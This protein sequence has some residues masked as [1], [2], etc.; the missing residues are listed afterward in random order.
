MPGYKLG[1]H[2]FNGQ[3]YYCTS[4]PR[5]ISPALRDSQV[6]FGARWP[7]IYELTRRLLIT[8]ESG[9]DQLWT[10]LAHLKL[11]CDSLPLWRQDTRNVRPAQACIIV[12]PINCGKTVLFERKAPS[13]G[14]RAECFFGD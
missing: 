11:S 8:P 12:G 13:F 6:K 5:P 14:A 4:S 7:V 10:L 9:E 2:A 1:L 3:R